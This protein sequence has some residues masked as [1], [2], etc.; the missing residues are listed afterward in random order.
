[1]SEPGLVRLSFQVRL[2]TFVDAVLGGEGGCGTPVL[3]PP[4]PGAPPAT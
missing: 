4:A 2:G 1:V 3:G